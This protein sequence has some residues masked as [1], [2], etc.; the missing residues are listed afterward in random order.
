DEVSMR[1][2]TKPST[3]MP[4]G[5][6]RKPE[7]SVA[8]VIVAVVLSRTRRATKNPPAGGTLVGLPQRQGLP[9]PS[10]QESSA[11][12]RFRGTPSPSPSRYEQPNHRSIGSLPLTPFARCSSERLPGAMRRRPP[13]Q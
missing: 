8:A 12:R 13:D 3:Q 6:A 4:V 9:G 2:D 1:R 5:I 11:S 10:R 7:P